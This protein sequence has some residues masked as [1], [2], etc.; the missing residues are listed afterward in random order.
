VD[1]FEEVSILAI[2]VALSAG[3]SFLDMS[4]PFAQG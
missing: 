4:K 3:V 2:G 1:I